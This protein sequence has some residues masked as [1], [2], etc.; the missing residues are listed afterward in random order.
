LTDREDG[1]AHNIG[2]CNIGAEAIPISIGSLFG[3]GSGRSF[4]MLLFVLIFIISFSIGQRF[5]A[6]DFQIPQHRKALSLVA[7]FQRHPTMQQ[8]LI[9]IFTLTT[10]NSYSQKLDITTIDKSKVLATLLD[11]ASKSK[12][13]TQLNGKQENTLRKKWTART[14]LLSDGKIIVEFFDK[15]AILI[16]NS[17]EFKKLDR[18]RFAKNTVGFLKKNISY[19]IEMTIEEGTK[20][21]ENGKPKRLQNLK[22]EM[23]QYYD[24]EVYEL[25][26]GQILFLDKSE[27]QKSSTIYADL[28]T[29]CSDNSTITDLVYGSEDDE[30]L[31]KKIANGDPL[32]DYVP[33]DHLIYPKYESEVI[34][35]HKLTL[36]D[37]KVF[38]AADFYGNLYKSEKGYYIL[39]D[40]FNQLNIP[41]TAKLGIGTLKVY[42]TL[43][44]VRNAQK[45]Y[46][47]FKDEAV[48]SEHF[49]QKLSDKNGKDFPKY[50]PQLIDSLP[51]I[52]NFDKEQL[53]FD[54]LGIDLV[55]EA[56]K[57]NG[58]NYKLFDSWFPSILAYYGQCY[59][60][61]KNEGKWTMY[62]DKE[63]KVWIP[64]IKLNDGTSAWDWRDFYKGL[65]EGPIPL[66][67]AGDWDGSRK[68]MRADFKR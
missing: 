9:I 68:K 22:S 47:E 31:M 20:I 29:L 6:E 46:E 7:I 14:F 18:V 33:S 63:N 64:E 21:V 15:Q 60:I 36:I 55:D 25:A 50:V 43:D 13:L 16:E 32:L 53:S 10:L 65:Y 57:W 61:D 58:T 62:F 19:K 12:L 30:Y 40:D 39:I 52:L 23:P 3:F 1:Y 34:K 42:N 2:F 56:L 41:K 8:I 24:F 45:R 35:N 11:S 17:N 27:M 5:R 48:K 28:K 67:W 54:S 4:S 26:T 38:V 59:I 51:S 44:E 37:T 66:T 49:Y